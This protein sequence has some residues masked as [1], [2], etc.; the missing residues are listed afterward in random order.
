MVVGGRFVTR[1]VL[2]QPR[3]KNWR[4][5]VMMNIWILTNW[6][7]SVEHVTVLNE[8]DFC[9][10]FLLSSS[11]SSPFIYFPSSHQE[12]HYFFFHIYFAGSS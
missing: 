10:L 12:K 6:Q 11:T 8:L 3:R 7:R 4:W 5:R 2:K 1:R 9:Y